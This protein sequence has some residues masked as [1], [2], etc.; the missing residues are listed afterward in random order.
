MQDNRVDL[1]GIKVYPFKS[2]DELLELAFNRCG[3]LVAVNAEKI[4]NATAE[5]KTLINDNIGYCD[6]VGAVKAVRKKSGIPV[7]KIPGCELWLD[8]IREGLLT[9]KKFYLVGGKEEVI[10]ATVSKLRKDFPRLNIV[11]YRNG[12]LRE[13]NA[14]DVLIRDIV[15]KSPDVVFVAMGSPKQEFLMQEMLRV[16]P[17]LYQGLGGSFDVY[18]GNVKRAPQIF[19]KLGL[20]W[21]YRLLKQPT[22]IKRQVV[23]FKFVIS[24]Y[25]NRL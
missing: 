8:I 23:Y 14:K 17:A 11:G 7:V 15:E 12:Y 21:L 25:L 13:P 19:C 22:R 1:K 4:M 16:H 10:E 2:K 6:G 24:Y 18:V 3:I 5:L 20:E 9:G